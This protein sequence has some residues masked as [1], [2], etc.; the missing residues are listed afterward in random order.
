MRPREESGCLRTQAHGGSPRRHTAASTAS[1]PPAPGTLTRCHEGGDHGQ[2]QNPS[3][4]ASAPMSAAGPGEDPV[5]AQS[6]SM[7]SLVQRGCPRLP[8]ARNREDD[9]KDASP[10]VPTWV[11][12][13]LL[14]KHC[15][16][17]P[18]CTPPLMLPTL[19]A[20]AGS[21]TD[22]AVSC[23]TWGGLRNPATSLLCAPGPGVCDTEEGGG[24]RIVPSS[25]RSTQGLFVQGCCAY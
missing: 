12:W 16:P 14:L 13:S 6:V 15:P 19:G 11:P 18:L 8:P 9:G 2:S 5:G 21:M 3:P 17:N 22:R 10:W 1:L 7:K 25:K 4:T 23:L 24:H 20:G